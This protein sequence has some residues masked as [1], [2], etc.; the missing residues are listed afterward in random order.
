M[1]LY[2]NF[3][4]STLFMFKN[5]GFSNPKF[6]VLTSST[7]IITLLS[8]NLFFLMKMLIIVPNSAILAVIP[9]AIFAEKKSDKYFTKI[10][11]HEISSYAHKE[12]KKILNIITVIA[13]YLAALISV[14]ISAGISKSFE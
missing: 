10:Y 1:G 7:L 4:F 13:Y 12:S 5:L 9:I 14:L 11:E 8:L 3:M 2:L 6:Y